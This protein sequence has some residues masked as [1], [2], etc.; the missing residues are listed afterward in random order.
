M[1]RELKDIP[2]DTPIP[3]AATLY[4]WYEPDEAWIT[5]DRYVNVE[6]FQKARRPQPEAPDGGGAA[7]RLPLRRHAGLFEEKEEEQS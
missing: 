6:V 2:L 1:P 7:A 5:W 4:L 3:T